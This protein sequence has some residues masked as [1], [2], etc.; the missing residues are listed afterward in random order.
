MDFKIKKID[1]TT[2]VYHDSLTN[3][4]IAVC[5]TV[6]NKY[7]SGKTYHIAWHPDA[8]KLYSLTNDLTHTNF[9]TTESSAAVGTLIE[10]KYHEVQN[11]TTKDPLHA[12]FAGKIT[13]PNQTKDASD[14]IEF[15]EF[16]L[17]DAD[18]K[19]VASMY[20]NSKLAS[21]IGVNPESFNTSYNNDKYRLAHLVFHGEQPT[22][23][24]FSQSTKKHPGNDPIAMMH[25]VR[26]WLDTKDKEPSFV[27]HYKQ[28][29]LHVYKT[30]LTPENATI[31]YVNHLK[32]DSAY[33]T[34][35]FEHVSPTV[36]IAKKK[37]S[38]SSMYSTHGMYEIID[39]STP[40]QLHH[41][42]HEIHPVDSYKTEPLN[43]I[44]E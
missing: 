33:D 8:R 1:D 42:K 21:D 39:S 4:P 22:A 41:I 11:S 27:G 28:T 19:H 35:K 29:G 25:Q 5:K 31:A 24:K 40:G 3:D 15:H 37:S 23:E 10:R 38:N 32:S 7:K 6:N 34:H 26:H 18:N 13:K 30:K 43:K 44:I 14:D 16:H 17:H 9:S 2:S 36:T 12:V 20:V